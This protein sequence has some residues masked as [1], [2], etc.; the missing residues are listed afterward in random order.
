MAQSSKWHATREARM[1]ELFDGKQFTVESEFKNEEPQETPLGYKVKSGWRLVSTD[2]SMHIVVGKSLLNKLADSGAVEKPATRKR[3]RPRKE[4]PL[5]QA[6]QWASR[7]IPD[8]AQQITQAGP[9]YDNPN[10]D[11]KA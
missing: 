5:E 9:T 6:E 2:G 4:Q 11:Q 7:D 3:G 10:A 1:K 8:D